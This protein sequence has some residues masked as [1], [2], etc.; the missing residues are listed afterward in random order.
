MRRMHWCA[1]AFGLVA[2]LVGGTMVGADPATR[3]LVGSRDDRDEGLRNRADDEAEHAP[4]QAKHRP[5]AVPDTAKRPASAWD[6]GKVPAH[7][8]PDG[9]SV[10]DALRQAPM[11]MT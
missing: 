1:M 9:H 6:R 7:V 4:P 8:T 10:P 3:P 2:G 5:P 11:T